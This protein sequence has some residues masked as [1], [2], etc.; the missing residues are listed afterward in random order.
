MVGVKLK[1]YYIKSVK[2]CDNIA[3]DVK[4]ASSG[5]KYRT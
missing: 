5:T 3:F 1:G 2:A 4:A